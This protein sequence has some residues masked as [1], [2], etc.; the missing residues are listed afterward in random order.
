[1]QIFPH[2]IKKSDEDL[3]LSLNQV[4]AIIN[5]SNGGS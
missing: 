2:F 3:P 4:A 5:Q 1:M